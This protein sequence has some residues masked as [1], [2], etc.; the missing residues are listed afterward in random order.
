MFFG[1]LLN[2]LQQNGFRTGRIQDLSDRYLNESGVEDALD[3]EFRQAQR[4]P[5]LL[6]CFRHIAI[7][8]AE[9]TQPKRYLCGGHIR[10]SIFSRQSTIPAFIV[11]MALH[12]P[13]ASMLYS[14][15][16]R[17]FFTF[18]QIDITMHH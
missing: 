16:V 15:F 2:Q 4:Y 14:T 3:Q 7:S 5:W 9:K 10:I 13:K 11:L 8:P 17:D 6:E 18:V 12:I 1:I